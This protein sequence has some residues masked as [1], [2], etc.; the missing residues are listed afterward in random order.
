[1][2]YV[3]TTLQVKDMVESLKFYQE[4]VG[5]NISSQFDA[6]PDRKIVFLGDGD[7]KIELIYS[8]ENKTVDIGK[9]ISIGFET[10]SVDE[11]MEFVKQK[12]IAVHSGP[13]EP[14][15]HTKFFYVQ[16][17]SGLRVQFIEHK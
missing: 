15:P 3:H 14:N 11:M 16:D 4:I 13:F 12:G 17:P 9:D 5:L 7:T 1:M 2:N 8:P 6:G 10:G